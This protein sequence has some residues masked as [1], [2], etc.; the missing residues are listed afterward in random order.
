MPKFTLDLTPACRTALTN[1]TITP[2][3]F[4]LSAGQLPRPVYQE[5]NARL[6]AAGFKWNK[7][8][9]CHVLIHGT[10]APQ[11]VQAMLSTGQV[12]DTAKERKVERQAFYTPDHIAEEVAELAG[13]SGFTV[14]EPSAGHGAL[15]LA[16]LRMQAKSVHCFEIDREAA[17]ALEEMDLPVLGDDFLHN[18]ADSE[19]MRY[20]RIVMNPPFTRG[21][22]TKH[23]HHACEHWLSR[24]GILTAIVCD[25]GQ[26]RTDLPAHQ[27][28]KRYPSGAFRSSGTGICTLVIQITK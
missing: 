14:L 17:K 10:D 9:K 16:C 20:P 23:V 1:G 28:L 27:V 4:T 15:A 5:V 19:G 25:K 21:A 7:K 18:T 3:S 2:D 8:R 6:E 24:G 22:D 11:I 26:P 12:K 13:V